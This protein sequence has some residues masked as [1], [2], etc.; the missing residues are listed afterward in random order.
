MPVIKGNIEYNS[1]EIIL[2]SIQGCSFVSAML[3]QLSC[4]NS[5][6]PQAQDV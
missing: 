4:S 3:L 1:L 2:F 5:N 6:A